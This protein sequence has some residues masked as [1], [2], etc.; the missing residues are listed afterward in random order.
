MEL[1]VNMISN[2]MYSIHQMIIE[3][4]MLLANFF[5]DKNRFERI[6]YQSNSTPSTKV[7][8]I[9]K[10]FKNHKEEGF[11]ALAWSSGEETCV[12]EKLLPGIEDRNQKVDFSK[13]LAQSMRQIRGY[14]KLCDY[15]E[16]RRLIS[17]DSS[18]E[19]HE[20]KLMKL[21]E[22]MKPDEP[23]KSRRSNQWQDVGFQGDDPAT[24]FRGMG[25]LG[26]EQLIFFSQYDQEN[27]LHCL[28][29]SLH[30]RIGFPYAICRVFKLYCDFWNHEDPSSVMM[31]NL[32]KQKFTVHLVE[33]L[34]REK[35][36]LFEANLEDII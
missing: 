36:N 17:Y 32:V 19:E 10:A 33:Y 5:S 29:I 15:V 13:S 30:P 20:K 35:A 16:S 11:R 22:L 14:N 1:L 25:I 3:G 9:E 7:L 21:W 24:D 26:L 4:F 34:R 23:L 12:A 18:N 31:F 8:N 28:R 6:M 2:V 27:A